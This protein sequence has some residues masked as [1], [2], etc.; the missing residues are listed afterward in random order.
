MTADND[1]RVDARETGKVVPCHW[2]NARPITPAS[3]NPA[4]SRLRNC[5]KW[6]NRGTKTMQ[7]PGPQGET[8]THRVGNS[9]RLGGWRLDAAAARRWR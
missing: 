6:W 2:R 5:R 9:R 8:T 3:D 4:S 7:H 1:G